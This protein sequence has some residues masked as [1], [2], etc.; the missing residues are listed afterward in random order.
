MINTF[1]SGIRQRLHKANVAV[2]TIK[3][4]FVDTPMTAHFKKGA[5]WAKPDLV[6]VKIVKAIDQR[7]DEIYIPSFWCFIM[8]VIKMIP[9]NIFKRIKI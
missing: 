9:E 2:V 5:L 1:T 8:T 7:K 4:G 6:S 3:P